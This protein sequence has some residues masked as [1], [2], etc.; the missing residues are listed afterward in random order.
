MTG[1]YE[2]AGQL[3]PSGAS[4]APAG[5]FCDLTLTK[6]LTANRAI[7]FDSTYGHVASS[8]AGPA[9]ASAVFY[10]TGD[11]FNVTVTGMRLYAPPAAGADRF[12]PT[13]FSLSENYKSSQTVTTP[14]PQTAQHLAIPHDLTFSDID[15]DG[16]YLG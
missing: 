13:A 7:V 16:T 15:L 12:L 6:W 8:W 5:A 3:V 4:A 10:I 2:K 14:T 9:N 11:T 1:G